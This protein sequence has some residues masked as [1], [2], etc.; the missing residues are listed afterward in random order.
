MLVRVSSSVKVIWNSV[1][2]KSGVRWHICCFSITAIFAES[3][4]N[5]GPHFNILAVSFWCNGN[6][7]GRDCWILLIDASWRDTR[8][9]ISPIFI[10]RFWLSWP[11]V[12][13]SSIICGRFLIRPHVL[14][15]VCYVNLSVSWSGECHCQCEIVHSKIC[16]FLW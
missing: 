1:I 8:F 4:E 13:G 6:S 5:V 12:S 14:L 10:G 9:T 11:K 16:E 3:N 2:S 15:W 7:V